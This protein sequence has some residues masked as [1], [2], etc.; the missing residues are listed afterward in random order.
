VEESKTYLTRVIREVRPDILHLNQYCYGDLPVDVA[1]ILVVHSD[2]VSWWVA[3]KGHEPEESNWIRWYRETVKRGIQGAETVVAPSRWM[4][5]AFSQCY[6]K[7]GDALVIHN[8]RNAKHFSTDQVKQNFVLSSGR[9]WDAGKQLALLLKHKHP[10]PIE[11]AGTMEEP[12]N[13]RALNEQ[14][15][16]E[17]NVRFLGPCSA[18]RMRELFGRAA[19]YVATSCYEPFGLAPLEAA[20]SRCALILNDIPSF[21][22]LWGS[23]AFYFRTNDA[24]DLAQAVRLFSGSPELRY[25][26]GVAAYERA[27]EMFSSEAMITKYERL[28]QSV[29]QL[30]R[31]A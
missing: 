6:K 2:V 29:A 15:I 24:D 30:S 23:A 5:D 13:T 12:G 20:L 9:L 21:R 19:V 18:A 1:R 16:N 27:T 11:V 31:A 28:Y 14:M 8:G 17:S 3:V 4:L 25:S 10:V 22:E 26:F 7:P